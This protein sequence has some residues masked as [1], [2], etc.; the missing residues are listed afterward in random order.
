MKKWSIRIG[1]ILLILVSGIILFSP[2][3]NQDKFPYKLIKQTIE[4][5]APVDTVFNYLGNSDNASDWSVYVDHISPLNAE[6]YPDGVVGST[7]RC[8]CEADE[9]GTQW[10]ELITEV[11]PNKKRQLTIYNLKGFPIDLENLA[12]EQIYEKISDTK[13]S[14]TF[15]VFFKDVEP[16]LFDQFKIYLSGYRI[17]SI[18]SRTWL[19]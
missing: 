15:T 18:L 6:S 11:I 1:L 4:I 17:K 12:T 16:T 3:G 7:R 10:D 5:D 2:Y 19:T 13:C 9:T 8:F 14:V